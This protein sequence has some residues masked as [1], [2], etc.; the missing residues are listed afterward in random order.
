[1][2]ISEEGLIRYYTGPAHEALN[3]ALKS[4][5]NLSPELLEF[6]N[7]L[8]GALDKL[9][10]YE[11]IVYRGLGEVESIGAEFWTVGQ[12]ISSPAFTSSSKSLNIAEQY[13]NF[14][15]GHVIYQIESKSGKLIEDVSLLPADQEVLFKTGR[16]FEVL[17]PATPN[18]NNPSILVVTLKEL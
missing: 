17:I 3:T 14:R 2:H 6:K 7:V 4:Q 5:G 18:P 16:E 13:M 15:G 8:N 9:P 12:K 11:N 1:M 10:N